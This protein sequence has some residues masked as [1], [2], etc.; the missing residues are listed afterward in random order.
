VD[1]SRDIY[2]GESK[3]DTR[4]A[5]VIADQTRM[6]PNLQELTA[7]EGGLS[8]LRILLARRRD[9]VVDQTGT[10]NRLRDVLLSSFPALWKGLWISPAEAL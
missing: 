6:K 8:E 4:D 5:H 7:D 3:T 9:L 10:I 2:P 1:R